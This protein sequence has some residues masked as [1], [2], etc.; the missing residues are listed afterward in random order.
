MR[1]LLASSLALVFGLLTLAP[2]LARGEQAPGFA[3]LDRTDD[4]TKIATSLAFTSFD[5]SGASGQRFDLHGQYVHPQLGWGGYGVLSWG[6][7]STNFGSESGLGNLEVGG[8]YAIPGEVPVIL[9]GGIALDTASDEDAFIALLTGVH[10]LTDAG[11]QLPDTTSLRLSVSPTLRQGQGYFRADA[12]LDLPLGHDFVDMF[13]RFNVAGGIDLG[14]VALQAEL[15]NIIEISDGD[16]DTVHVLG[17]GARYL[18]H[19]VV[20]PSLT[21][22]IPLDSDVSDVIDFVLVIGVD[23]KIPTAGPV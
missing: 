21:L 17:L 15:V 3:L 18:G 16:N 7:I 10:R 1:A 20:Q 8:L 22:A 13:L 9:R 4:Q 5:A 11:T 19:P 14:G 12:G 23:F 2:G 6:R